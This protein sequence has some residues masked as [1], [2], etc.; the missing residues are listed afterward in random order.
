[1]DISGG[2]V[3]LWINDVVQDKCKILKKPVESDFFFHKRYEEKQKNELNKKH[4][5]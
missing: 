3:S 1:M 2:F 5:W 4:K